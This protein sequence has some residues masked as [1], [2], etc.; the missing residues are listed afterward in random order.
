MLGDEEQVRG[1]WNNKWRFCGSYG[2][3]GLLASTGKERHIEC[4]RRWVTK[5]PRGHKGRL[6]LLGA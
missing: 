4:F 5:M 3:R 1:R 6:G 2:R